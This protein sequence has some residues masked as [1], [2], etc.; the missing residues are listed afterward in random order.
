MWP[1][2]GFSPTCV[3]TF[4]LRWIHCRCLW[5]HVHTV[6]A[7]CLLTTKESSCICAEK[8]S[9]TSGLV[10]LSLY[11]SRAQLLPLALSLEC[12]GENK[13]SV[14]LHL[15][16]ASCPVQEPMYLLPRLP[17]PPQSVLAIWPMGL[18]IMGQRWSRVWSMQPDSQVSSN[19]DF[20]P[21]E[22]FDSRGD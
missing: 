11:F 22:L 17:F 12:L 19:P 5:V 20:S 10:L 9:L 2:Q 6:G 21:P 14:L 1:V 16:N 13:A 15:T 4:L 8:F 3:R 7:P 18:P